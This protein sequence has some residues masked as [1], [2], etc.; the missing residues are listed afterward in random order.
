[1]TKVILTL[2]VLVMTAAAI[3]EVKLA[4]DL[5]KALASERRVSAR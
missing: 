3:L 1:M 5:D 4:T 2:L